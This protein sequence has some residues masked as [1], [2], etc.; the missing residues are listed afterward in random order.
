MVNCIDFSGKCEPLKKPDKQ[1]VKLESSS[2]YSPEKA[3]NYKK[4]LEQQGA[5]K[6]KKSK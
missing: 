4:L 6:I 2:I 3:L 1:I 5:G